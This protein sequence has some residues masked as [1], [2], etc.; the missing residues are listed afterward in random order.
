MSNRD[1]TL[2]TG[3]ASGI[4]RH[5]TTRLARRG[6]SIWATDLEEAQLESVRDEEWSDFDV[7]VRPLDVTSPDDWRETLET[8][9]REPVRLERCLNVAGYL[10]AGYVHETT[11]EAI[12]QQIDVNLKGTLYAMRLVGGHMVEQGGGHLVNVGSLA[13]LAPVSGLDVYAGS[14]FG[15]RGATISAARELNDRGVDVTLVMPDAV[16]T[17]MLRE[18]SDRDEAAV[19]FSGGRPLTVEEVGDV[20]VDDVLPDRPL[21]VCL[22]ESR[23]ILG[24]L[25]GL[26]PSWAQSLEPWVRNIGRRA[27]E[28]YRDHLQ[29]REPRDG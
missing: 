15:V 2:V 28:N 10:K 6:E 3:A 14:K 22:P 5:V 1:I 9:D 27:L 18:E 26:L 29:S 23:G 8:I 7:R 20:F 19:V 12:D 16:D 4:G 21:E 24:R 17:P 13:S 11:I 25:T